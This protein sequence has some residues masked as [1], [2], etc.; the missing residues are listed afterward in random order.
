[1]TNQVFN[2]E[3]GWS[4]FSSALGLF[5]KMLVPAKTESK[6]AAKIILMDFFIKPPLKNKIK[7]LPM[8]LCYVSNF[9]TKNKCNP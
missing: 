5:A 3:L 1:M 4:F 9:I 7:K 2:R 8:Q 6:T